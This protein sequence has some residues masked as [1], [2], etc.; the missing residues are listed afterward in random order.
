[1]AVPEGNE[2][3]EAHAVTLAPGQPLPVPELP[4]EAEA[5]V[6]AEAVAAPDAAVEAEAAEVVGA[7]MPAAASKAKAPA[8]AME[9]G[10][11]AV[12]SPQVPASWMPRIRRRSKT[13]DV[14]RAVVSHDVD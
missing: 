7:E 12:V 11:A 9:A 2:T 1:M 4:V 13:V 10:P 3:G 8:L 14:I 5:E 6:A